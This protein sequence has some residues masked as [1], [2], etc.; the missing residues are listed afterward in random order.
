MPKPLDSETVHHRVHTEWQWPLSGVHSGLV[1]K[2]AQDGEGGRVDSHYIY[3]YHNVQSCDERA[4]TPIS[5]I[6]L[7]VLCAV[8]SSIECKSTEFLLN[9]AGAR[10]SESKA[11]LA[12]A[13][14]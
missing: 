2:F 12:T 1:E 14:G 10:D 6:S 11:K 5:T 7:Y 4:D 9:R 8:Y 3:E 13:T